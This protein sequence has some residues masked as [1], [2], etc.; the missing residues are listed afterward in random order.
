LRKAQLYLYKRLR[1]RYKSSLLCFIEAYNERIEPAFSDIDDEV[2]KIEEDYYDELTSG[3]G[4]DDYDKAIDI[5]EEEAFFK[6]LERY[7]ILSLLRYQSLAGWIALL[8]QIWE[9]QIIGFLSDELR[10]EGF[11]EVNI[12][13]KNVEPY[14]RQ[15]GVE[16]KNFTCWE[17][18]VEM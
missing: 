6:A 10:K 8:S 18:I 14:F 13:Y 15:F 9:Q 7:Q 16:F 12:K 2:K 1:E 5:A 4:P 17:T 11:T 3:L